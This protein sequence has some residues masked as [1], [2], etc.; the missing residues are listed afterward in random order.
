MNQ[1]EDWSEKYSLSSLSLSH[2]SLSL[3]RSL[4]HYNCKLICYLYT[5][6]RPNLKNFEEIRDAHRTVLPDPGQS[7]S[8]L[9]T[10]GR[11]AVQR[12]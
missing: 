9:A 1:S 8:R 2:L 7:P 6:C 11:E 4:S 10:R 12:P 5:T 3:S